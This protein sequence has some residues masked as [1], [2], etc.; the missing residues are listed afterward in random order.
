MKV[1]KS[2]MIDPTNKVVVDIVKLIDVMIKCLKLRLSVYQVKV[3]SCH[4]LILNQRINSWIVVLGLNLALH[5]ITLSVL[6]T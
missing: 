5:R 4:L 3:Y 6:R 2:L 1:G